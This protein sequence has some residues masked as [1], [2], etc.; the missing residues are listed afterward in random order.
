MATKKGKKKKFQPVKHPG[1]ATRKAKREGLS[2]S[3]WEQKHKNDPGQ[4]GK[5]AR[6]PL[7]AKKW[8]KGGKHRGTTLKGHGSSGRKAKGAKLRKGKALKGQGGLK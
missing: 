5:Q 8:K 1:A 7:I 2:L 6:F 4:T 3:A